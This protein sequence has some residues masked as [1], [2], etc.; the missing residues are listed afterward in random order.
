[1]AHACGTAYRNDLSRI[2]ADVLKKL[3]RETFRI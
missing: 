1:V 2:S 3:L